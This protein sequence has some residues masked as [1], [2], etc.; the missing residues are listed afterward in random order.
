MLN[1]RQTNPIATLD[2]QINQ[3]HNYNKETRQKVQKARL[4]EKPK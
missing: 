2:P 4:S 1:I 3:R